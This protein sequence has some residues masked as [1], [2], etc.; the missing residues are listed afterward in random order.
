MKWTMQ[1]KDDK[2]AKPRELTF[3]ARFLN[4]AGVWVYAGEAWLRHQGEGVV[5]FH[6]PGLEE[7]AIGI[8]EVFPSIRKHVQS[9]FDLTVPRDQEVKLYTSMK[10][11]Q[12]GICLSYVDG[13]GG[14]NEPGESIRQLA[15]RGQKGE[16]SRVVLAHEFGHVCTFEL[17]GKSTDIPWWVI[18]GVAEFSA[19]EY[20]KSAERN[21]R[22]MRK[23]SKDGRLADWK[24]LAVFGEVTGANYGKVYSQ[25]HSMVNFITT[26]FGQ[27]KRTAWLAQMAKGKSL[28]E[29]TQE[30]FAQ[31]FEQLDKEWHDEVAKVVEEEE[32]EKKPE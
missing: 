19:Q 25:G 10:H 26:K 9:L 3:K 6:E 29:A 32:K 8:A 23:M 30:I 4:E 7:L 31:S 20:A 18:E 14:W 24:D 11:L 12:A 2:P 1:G 15:H 16:G 28:A 17:G 13:L 22:S 5:V 27:T 21:A